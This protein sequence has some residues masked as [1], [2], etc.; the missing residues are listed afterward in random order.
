[1]TEARKSR[2]RRTSALALGL[3][4]NR[5]PFVLRGIYNLQDGSY[6]GEERRS[7]YK[8]EGGSHQAWRRDWYNK[9]EYT[10]FLN[11]SNQVIAWEFLRRNLNYQRVCDEMV[12]YV[13]SHDSQL[14]GNYYDDKDRSILRK[15]FSGNTQYFEDAFGIDTFSVYYKEALP[16]FLN[17]RIVQSYWLK[18]K[19]SRWVQ[20]TYV[21]ETNYGSY[22][23]GLLIAH[24]DLRLKLRDQI[25]ILE[26]EIVN[27][28]KQKNISIRN[29][30]KEKGRDDFVT[31][32]RLLDAVAANAN[33]DDMLS[34]IGKKGDNG[35]YTALNRWLKRASE[36]ADH[37]YRALIL[38]P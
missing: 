11:Q 16:N 6:S 32:L 29:F 2:G 37:G 15:I 25:K 30:G 5:K 28:K 3:L 34:I 1:M 10:P 21:F 24:I 17:A 31:Y 19:G 22:R 9:S 13:N 36:M 26:K 20:Q 23:D 14:R 35:K 27:I 38:S 18:E 12:S 8:S 4:A 33:K 7:I